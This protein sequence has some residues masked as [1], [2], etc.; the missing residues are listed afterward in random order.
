MNKKNF[1]LFSNIIPVKGASRSTLCD[2]QNNKYFFIPNG[3]C[4]ILENYNGKSIDFIKQEFKNK[5]NGI[6]D[7]Y[8]NFLTLNN[9]IFFDENPEFF[10]RMNLKWDSPSQITNMV[11]DYDTI[12][13]DFESIILQLE[14]LKCSYLQ[15][16][17]FKETTIE[18]VSRMAQFIKEQKSRIASVNFIMPSSVKFTK[19]ELEDLLKQN[20]RIHSIII[21]NALENKNFDPIRREMGYLIYVTKNILNEKHCGI[22][23]EDYFYSNIKLFTESQQFNTCLNRKISVDKQGSIKNCPSMPQ[24]YGNIKNTKLEEALNHP[25]FKKFWNIKKD[26]IKVCQ[27]CEFRH[28]CTDCRAY[29]ENPKDNYSKPLKCG[30]SPYTNEWEEWSENPLKQKAIEYYGMQE[31]VKKND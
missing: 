10:P 5:Y 13:H 23:N 18:N 14:K 15:I 31:L 4:D 22:I 16:R 1:I 17:F 28:I 12:N 29:V 25:N 26:D 3:L 27:D 6:I 24:S 20:P 9:F 11:I 19:L 8:F 30:Y 21:Y 7:E 2:L